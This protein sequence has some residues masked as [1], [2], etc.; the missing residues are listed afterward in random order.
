M[1]LQDTHKTDVDIT[2]TEEF[3]KAAELEKQASIILE[4]YRPS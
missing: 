2:A 1:N 4:Q 3:K